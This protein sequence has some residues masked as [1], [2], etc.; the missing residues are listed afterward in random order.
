M[1]VKTPQ[2]LV[3]VCSGRFSVVRRLTSQDIKVEIIW[4]KTT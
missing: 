1:K 3:Q 4:R 2:T